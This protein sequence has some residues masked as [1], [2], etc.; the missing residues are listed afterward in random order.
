M[1]ITDIDPAWDGTTLNASSTASPGYCP[2]CRR[3]GIWAETCASLVH[4]LAEEMTYRRREHMALPRIILTITSFLTWSSSAE[5]KMICIVCCS[6]GK[7]EYLVLAADRP[8][9]LC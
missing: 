2:T 7:Q 8:D 4:F 9:S 1:S 3:S 5:A 6:T